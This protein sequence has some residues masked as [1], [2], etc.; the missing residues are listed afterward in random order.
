MRFTFRLKKPKH[1]RFRLRD[2]EITLRWPWQSRKIK[3]E[4]WRSAPRLWRVPLRKPVGDLRHVFAS[5]RS[6]WEA[7]TQAYKLLCLLGHR[8]D[9]W[10]SSCGCLCD[11]C[12]DCEGN[13]ESQGFRETDLG[14]PVV[15]GPS[16]LK[17]AGAWL[18]SG[19][20]GEEEAA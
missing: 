7:H 1:L 8:E 17:D 5:A 9:P 16:P 10:E 19:R 15:I 20:T 11:G 18:P 6:G 3:P 13:D 4:E 2:H 14:I 12:E